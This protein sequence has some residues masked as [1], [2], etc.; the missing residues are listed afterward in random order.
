MQLKIGMQF[1]D[2]FESHYI[3]EIVGFVGGDA[4]RIGSHPICKVKFFQ[5]HTGI[6]ID[7]DDLGYFKDENGDVVVLGMNFVYMDFIGYRD[8]II[9]LKHK[10]INCIATQQFEKCCIIRDKLKKLG[11][12][13]NVVKELILEKI[14]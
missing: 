3:T 10:L 13:D 4:D 12:L 8:E 2:Q 9:D 5:R 11:E 14:I 1:K 7:G 6:E